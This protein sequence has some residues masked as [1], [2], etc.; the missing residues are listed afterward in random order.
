LTQ[1]LRGRYNRE[2]GF[3]QWA[4][5]NWFELLQTV[6]IITGSVFT[7]VSLRMDARSRRVSNLIAAT[8]QHREIWRELY[9]RPHL[10][11]VLEPAP[12]LDASPVTKEEELFVLFLILHLNGAYRAMK[13]NLFTEPEELDR[14]IHSF[15][16][17][18][19][20]RS[21]WRKFKNRQDRSFVNF[22][23]RQFQV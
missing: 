11:R 14:D 20:P 2:M 23:E 18:P 7:A 22:V 16:T 5:T 21:V 17:L 12:D 13:E 6:G 4:G 3:L 15:F 19:I 10:A 8:Q 1:S 9:D